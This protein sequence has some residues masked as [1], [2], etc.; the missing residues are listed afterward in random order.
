MFFFIIGIE[1]EEKW[2]FFKV[3]AYVDG[4]WKNNPAELVYFSCHLIIKLNDSNS[5]LANESSRIMARV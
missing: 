1:W 2:F 4:N 3:E 5:Q